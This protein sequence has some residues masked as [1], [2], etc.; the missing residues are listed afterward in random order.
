MIEIQN[1]EY[2]INKLPP[3]MITKLDIYINYLLDNLKMEGKKTYLSQNWAGDLI[4]FKDM[5]TSVGLQKKSLEW[6]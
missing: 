1:L 3:E 2:K 5:F 4:E 6:R